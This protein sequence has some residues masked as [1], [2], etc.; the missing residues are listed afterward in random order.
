MFY[1]VLAAL[2]MLFL[3]S[4]LLDP[5]LREH[6]LLF[7]A[8]WAA[9]AW[10]TLLAVL[11][12]VFDMLLIRAAGRRARQDLAKEVLRQKAAAEDDDAHA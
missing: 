4:T 3:G 5:W 9:C 8:W 10:I 1:T 2:L 11:L 12:A 6:L 7:L